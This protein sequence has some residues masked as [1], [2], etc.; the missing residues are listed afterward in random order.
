MVLKGLTSLLG[1]LTG[2]FHSLGEWVRKAPS[3]LELDVCRTW[4]KRTE[5]WFPDFVFVTQSYCPTS[6]FC[7][8]K[9]FTF[10]F[11]LTLYNLQSGKASRSPLKR[12]TRKGRSRRRHPSASVP[13]RP[14][15]SE[16][17]G[18]SIS[19]SSTCLS[20]VKGPRVLLKRHTLLF[21]DRLDAISS[22]T[23]LSGRLPAPSPQTTGK[24][25]APPTPS[26]PRGQFLQFLHLFR[27]E[28]HMETCHCHR[29]QGCVTPVDPWIY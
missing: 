22:W 24:A 8:F 14:H 6:L 17:A 20:E 15:V 28:Y 7:T 3:L 5:F 2:L 10:P 18:P 26:S 1:K 27:G 9:I 25:S 16:V 12:L 11:K 23:D 4:L 29:L 21:G 19:C 13:D